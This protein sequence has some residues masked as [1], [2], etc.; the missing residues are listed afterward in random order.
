MMTKLHELASIG[1]AIWLDY[2]RRSLITSGELQ[3]LVDKGL[4]GMTSNPAIFDKAISESDDYDAQL[5]DLI[6]QHKSAQGMYEALVV[7][8]I[9]DAADILRPVYE[10]TNGGDGYV[11]LEANP[12]LAHDTGGTE[13][14]IRRLR[15]LVN[16]PNVMYKV[17]ATAEGIPVVEHLTGEG[18]NINITLMFSMAHYE[19][20]ANAYLAG[21]EKLTSSGGDLSR[22]ASVA[23]FFVSRVDKKVDKRL[24]ELGETPLQGKIGIA[25]A[26]NVYRRFT[27]IFD[28]ERWL[29]L[30]EKGARVQ[31]PLWAST[32]TKN[33]AYPDTLYVDNLIGPDTVNTL[34]PETLEAFLDHGTVA[35]TIDRSLDEAQA[36]L[37]RLAALGINLHMI[38]EELQREGID[39]FINR[40]DDL[41]QGIQKRRDRLPQR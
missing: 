15:D 17:P 28:S 21:L 40:L 4:R 30:A 19:S 3:T 37:Q 5:H 2:I 1:Q 25:N 13:A 18:T 11:S 41:M 16:R 20:V 9:Q 24:Q 22:I 23:S 35:R 29:R 8:D 31:R 7:K 33:P 10:Q 6:E 27:Q 34:P 32:S 39:Q 38:G 12:Y 14:E 36:Q 26:K